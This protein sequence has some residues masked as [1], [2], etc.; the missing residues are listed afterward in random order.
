MSRASVDAIRKKM[1]C[2]GDRGGREHENAW[3]P[4]VDGSQADGHCVS[5]VT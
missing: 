5:I 3:L 2:R 1:V 4:S